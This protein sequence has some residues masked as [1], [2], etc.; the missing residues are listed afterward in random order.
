MA[1]VPHYLKYGIQNGPPVKPV[2]VPL[3][4][5]RRTRLPVEPIKVFLQAIW[6]AKTLDLDLGT[7]DHLCKGQPEDYEALVKDLRPAYLLE[8]LALDEAAAA[9]EPCTKFISKLF[10]DSP[11]LR[12]VCF[13][14]YT[15]YEEDFESIKSAGFPFRQIT[16]LT[17][18]LDIEAIFEVLSCTPALVTASFAI[19]EE[20]WFDAEDPRVFHLEA[21]QDLTLRVVLNTR[22]I[23]NDI[24]DGDEDDCE[25][26]MRILEHIIAPALTRL[27][28]CLWGRRWSLDAFQRFMDNSLQPHIEHF[29]LDVTSGWLEDKLECLKMLPCLRTL[30]LTVDNDV[31]KLTD[32]YSIGEDFCTAMREI[33]TG[34]GDF[35]VCPRLEKLVIGHDALEQSALVSFADM[36][37]SRWKR[38]QEEGREFELV[39]MDLYPI[40]EDENEEEMLANMSPLLELK[41]SGLNLTIERD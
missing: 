37:A 22:H 20:S 36:I 32:D 21:L 7:I 41:A 17:M 23:G 35:M 9:L 10:A 6:R 33:D 16:A 40:K 11:L 3:S 8:H 2:P 29:R 13:D 31:E 19:L 30:R 14:N 4:A 12:T 28:L 1:L 26:P 24:D 5:V 34:T 15:I 18:K 27:Y 25:P 38:S 39:I